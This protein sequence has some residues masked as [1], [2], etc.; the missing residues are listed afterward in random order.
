MRAHDMPWQCGMG[1]DGQGRGVRKTGDRYDYAAALGSE[2]LAA[3]AVHRWEL[4]VGG[5]QQMWVGVASAGASLRHRPFDCAT[6]APVAATSES[7][8]AALHP[9]VAAG[10]S[11]SKP[12]SSAGSAIQ[13]GGINSGGG[14]GGSA[15]GSFYGVAL[16]SDGIDLRR[17]GAGAT[18]RLVGGPGAPHMGG[19]RSYERGERVTVEL[20][21]SAG[22]LLISVNGRPAAAAE[23]VPAGLHPYICFDYSESAVIVSATTRLPSAAPLPF[24]SGAKTQE[25]TMSWA[26]AADEEWAL[27]NGRW[28]AAQDAALATLSVEGVRLAGELPSPLLVAQRRILICMLNKGWAGQWEN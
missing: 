12:L 15:R 5:V 18:P 11:S 9:P 22:T 10:A 25:E 17:R 4:A 23:S 19:G 3:G 7:S 16:G 20:D 14:P 28:V 2:P 6:A 26:A 13:G 27:D 21:A 24:G 8:A 1:W